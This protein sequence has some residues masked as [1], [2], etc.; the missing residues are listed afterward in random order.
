MTSAISL[1]LAVLIG[2]FAYAGWAWREV[3]AGAS[4]LW[5]VA[6]IPI[7]AFAIPTLLTAWWFTLAWIYR[8][9]RPA[10]AQINASRIPGLFLHEM[11]AIA[12]SVPRM[13]LYRV[14][15]RDPRPAPATAPVL[16]LHGVLCNA[17]VWLPIVRH[18][19]ACGIGPVYTLS[20]GPPL[21]SI[22]RF[23]DQ[24]SDRIDAI[25]AATG[26]KQVIIVGHS[27]GGLV[28]RACARRH[29]SER[30]RRIITLGTPHHGS[31]LAYLFFGVSL[32][33]LRP[34][35]EWLT[36]LGDRRLPSDPPITSIWSWHDS[37][38]APQTSSVL[39]GAR[40]EALVGIGHNA[41]LGDVNLM[42]QLAR[43]IVETS[44]GSRR[45]PRRQTQRVG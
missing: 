12:W 41:L 11:L 22:D 34:R 35:S 45:G 38:V 14:L 36:A 42:R 37:M 9:P 23:A 15:L 8:A 6:G 39:D 27:M 31:V 17:G 32:T 5:F 26:A 4:A 40:N 25:L 16:L 2:S 3:A 18:L 29:R 13:I 10:A 20:Y 24:A 30:I 19:A 43:E 28:A 33:Q 7:A 1:S 21:A 44:D